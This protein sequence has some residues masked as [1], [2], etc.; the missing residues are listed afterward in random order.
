MRY[1]LLYLAL[2]I[3]GCTSGILGSASRS[4]LPKVERKILSN[5]LEVLFIE[6]RSLPRFAMSVQVLVNSN[7]D[8]AQLRGLTHF[9]A[10]AV[11][12][13][14]ESS[15]EEQLADRIADLGTSLEHSALPDSHLFSM[16][17]L[18]EV[19]N[20]VIG[21]FS[22][23]VTQA[24]FEPKSLNRLKT[25]LTADVLASMDFP[26]EVSGRLQ[27]RALFEGHSYATSSGVYL[28]T[29][30]K[31]DRR[32]V[33]KA[34]LKSYR[35]EVS[36]LFVSGD[37]DRADRELIEKVWSQWEARGVTRQS[38]PEWTPAFG[39]KSSPPSFFVA[40]PNTVQASVSVL[41]YVPSIE[42]TKDDFALKIAQFILGGHGESRL[43]KRV[44]EDLGLTYGIY[45]SI[46]KFEKANHFQISFQ[47][48]AVKFS[49]AHLETL[50]VYEDFLAKPSEVQEVE[51]AKA[52]LIGQFPTVAEDPHSFTRSLIDLMTLGK[53]QHYLY[54]YVQNLKAVSLSDLERVKK[55]HFP[56]AQALLTTVVGPAKINVSV[57]K[58]PGDLR[59][60][61]RKDLF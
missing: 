50:K 36:R 9:V 21:L 41:G 32:D 58:L 15:S 59:T 17:S 8:P 5:G 6:D 61:N 34:Y 33:I 12:R 27:L 29:L 18:S 7:S 37:I 16:R 2:L 42:N 49:Q 4:G 24:N 3:S 53:D 20:E 60:L 38:H 45:S 48:D 57:D 35:P 1:R 52:V 23:I 40:A 46:R 30:K 55:T 13:S 44:R 43:M 56:S 54:N 10:S 25:K 11:G 28:Q 26:S 19:K 47:T 31:V 14:T 51:E 22:E 39:Q